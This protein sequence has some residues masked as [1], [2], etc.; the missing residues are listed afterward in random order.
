MQEKIIKYITEKEYENKFIITTP[1]K[2][3]KEDIN[4]AIITVSIENIEIKGL[5]LNNYI[6][7]SGINNYKVDIM[8]TL[9][10]TVPMRQGIKKCYEIFYEISQTMFNNEINMVIDKISCQGIEFLKSSNSFLLTANM[11]IT[12]ITT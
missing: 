6:S 11:P 12:I 2:R 9:A 8:L 5:A 10:I 3:P 7:S 1:F 4:Q